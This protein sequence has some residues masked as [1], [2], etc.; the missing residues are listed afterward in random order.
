MATD[1]AEWPSIAISPEARELVNLF[2]L[3][4]ESKLDDAGLRL[5]KDVFAP[6]G[7]FVTPHGTFTGSDGEYTVFRLLLADLKGCKV[8][9]ASLAYCH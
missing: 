9:L 7:K 2:F 1:A 4:T 3:C 8:K 6:S 5:A